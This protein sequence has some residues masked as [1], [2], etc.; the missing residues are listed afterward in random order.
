MSAATRPPRHVHLIGS[1]AFAS[2]DEAFEQ[3]GRHLS[4]CATRFP[5]GETGDR[6]NW[7]M[8]QERTIGGHPQFELSGVRTDP[9]NPEAKFNLYRLRAGIDPAEIEFPTLGY[10]EEAKR[11]FATFDDKVASG[12]LPEDARFLVSLP[13]PL[14]FNWA[15]LPD[16]ADQEKVEPAY[17]R[18]MLREV[19]DIAAA[20]PA[21][22]LAIQWD[23]AAEMTALERGYWVGGKTG[24]SAEMDRRFDDMPNAFS[25]CAIRLCNAV[26][27]DVE[28]VVHLC[29]GDFGHR[30][31]IEPGSLAHCVDMA[32]RISA[33]IVR[34]LDLLHMPVPRDRD[35]DAYFEPLRALRPRPETVLCLGLIHHTDGVDGTLRRISTADRFVQDYSI[36]TECGLGRRPPETMQRLLEIHAEVARRA[37]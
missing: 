24:H 16:P 31:S 26:P 23:I 9:R 5:D 2:A 18:A 1:A 37:A 8:W 17:E 20:I 34:T 35:D 36:A 29:Y 7:I 28:L 25:A 21:D 27:A 10:T 4:F 32:N 11:S 15:F 12:I 3:F 6:M 13:T 14:A 33:G 30:H 19:A 22:R